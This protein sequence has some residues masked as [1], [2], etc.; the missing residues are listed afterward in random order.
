MTQDKRESV[1]EKVT[2]TIITLLAS[3][4][5]PWSKPWKGGKHG[6]AMSYATGKSYRGY[7]QMILSC[8]RASQGYKSAYWMTFNQAKA[9]G[10]SVKKGE[11]GT[12]IIYWNWI[13]KTVE[14]ADGTTS[15]KK[16]PFLRYYTVFNYDQTDGVKVAAGELPTTEPEPEFNPIEAAEA[17]VA[18]YK[19]CPPVAFGGDQACYR[20]MTDEIG[21][22]GKTSFV[23]PESFYST[24]F[25][26][27]THSTGHKSRL[28]RSGVTGPTYFG[29]D[30]YSQEEL[31]AE[32]G[33]SFLCG[34]SGIDKVTQD[35]SAAY[36]DHW[37]KVLK[38]DSKLVVMAASQ[39]QKAADLILGSTPK[40]AEETSA[41]QE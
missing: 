28:G 35:Q 4:V 3:G 40:A 26:E 19:S 27:M 16:I 12:P 33:A 13:K 5:V 25:H 23:S 24:Y 22:P 15:E 37:I 34:V 8:L 2:Q 6:S 11:K 30:V 29:S 1:Y 41:E 39:A 17:I 10:G 32:M 38:G 20:P 7:N 36:C 31:V 9:A 21:M 18:G 14:N